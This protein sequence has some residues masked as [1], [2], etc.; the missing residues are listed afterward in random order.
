MSKKELEKTTIQVTRKLQGQLSEFKHHS[1]ESFNDV[2]QRFVDGATDVYV[3]MILV[4]NELS[5][6]HSVVFQ[7][8]GD[9]RNLFIADINGIRQ[10]ELNEVQKLVKQAKPILGITREEAERILQLRIPIDG[11]QEDYMTIYAKIR[12][13]LETQ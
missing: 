7:L 4:D 6:S 10:I 8:G 11:D 1:R 9:Q 2:I 5:Q 13:W 3:E 12:K